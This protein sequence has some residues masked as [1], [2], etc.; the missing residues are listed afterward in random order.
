MDPLATSSTSSTSASMLMR[1]SSS[2]RLERTAR[3]STPA[4]MTR[5]SRRSQPRHTRC[6]RIRCA[7]S[8]MRPPSRMIHHTSMKPESSSSAP[9]KEERRWQSSSVFSWIVAA[10]MVDTSS[11]TY[12][13]GSSRH[14]HGQPISS[15]FGTSG[16][17]PAHW[18]APSF[19]SRSV[20][21]RIVLQKPRTPI[22]P[23]SESMRARSASASATARR[24][25]ADAPG[26]TA[27]AMTSPD[28]CRSCAA[29]ENIRSCVW[30]TSPRTR[31]PSELEDG[32]AGGSASPQPA[33]ALL[34]RREPCDSS[35]RRW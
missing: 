4:S 12:F 3:G 15:V 32:S 34:P 31:S 27:A 30:P 18:M 20:R 22:L 9:G 10:L 6:L 23:I 25:S 26:T 13:S 21:A 28:P 2:C 7:I 16:P 5:C 14:H 11:G 24:E 35:S 19:P 33:A 29:T 1:R 17:R 8:S